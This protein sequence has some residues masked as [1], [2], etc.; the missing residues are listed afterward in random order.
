MNGAQALVKT[1]LGAGVDVCF[2]NPGTSEMHF[3]AALDK[4]PEMRCILCLFEG[5]VTGAADGYWRMKGDVAATLLHL[6]PGFGNGFAN[7]HNAR[8]ARSGI[9]NIVG[10]HATYHLKY[11][12][13]LRGDVAGISRTISQWVRSSEDAMAVARDG[14]DA[15]RAARS[16]G[17]QIATLILPAN[18]AWEDADGPVE[19]AP[20][21]APHRPRMDEI[22]AAALEL[23]KPGA[24]L[25]LGGEA[26]HGGAL[27]ELAG[28]IA[29]ETGCVLLSDF[30]A[31]RLRRGAGAVEIRST[32]YVVEQNVELLR[33]IKSMVLCG[34]GRPVCFFAY[35][36]KPSVPEQA[37]CTIIPLCDPEMDYAWTLN[38][39]ADELG[40][41]GT[42]ANRRA[43][44]LPEVPSGAFDL[45][46]FGDAF[47][48]LLPEDAIVVDEAV[49]SG[50]ALDAPTQNARGHDWLKITGGSIGGG[51][52]TAV[53]AAV[54]CPD[55]KVIALSGDGSAMY[56]VQSLWTMAR[57]NLNVTI[58]VFAN[59][60]YQIL[61]G[62]L[63][64]VGAN[65][66]GENVRRMFDIVEPELDWVA[67]AK[68]HG[69][70]AQRITDMDEFIQA[71]QTGLARSGPFL[72]EVAC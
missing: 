20:V 72:I 33:D 18:T 47:A 9:V 5:G 7:L 6:S 53:G 16:H 42:K 1:L 4:H 3:V 36:G 51:F 41:R 23:R 27:T 54:A 28:Q 62:E 52:P 12:S 13:P 38:A 71:F 8:K 46:K 31:P 68:G 60:G 44:R 26:L 15:I 66:V 17:G 11:D 21:I 56:T 45:E 24:A 65:S 57:E 50:R 48:A 37:D 61:H 69:V 14:A 55:R 58:I 32:K 30:F 10:D 64:N 43:L 63:A 40:A 49:T 22:E 70:D 34:A 59:K 19:V 67:M 39:L 35:P 2:A 25:F 29:A